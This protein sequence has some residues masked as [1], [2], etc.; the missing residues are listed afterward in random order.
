MS[1]AI[2]TGAS[3]GLGSEYAR[4]L[5]TKQKRITE[6]WLIARRLERLEKLAGELEKLRP[7]LK[8]RAIPLDLLSEADIEAYGHLLSAMKPKVSYL[9]CAAGFGRIGENADIDRKELDRMILLNDKA[10]VD[11]TQ[12]TVPYVEEKG[13]ILEICSIA[14][15][16]PL[17]GLSVYGASKAFLISYSRSLR[18]EL[19]KRKIMVTAVCPYWVKDTEFIPTAQ[20]ETKNAG[21]VKHFPLASKMK[22]V[23][24]WSLFDAGLGLAV[25]TPRPV[26][27][28]G[29]FFAKFLPHG[30]L[31]SAWEGL[32]RL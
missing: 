32:R 11:I 27:L 10:A 25:S 28:G 2:I 3:S 1:V 4:Q 9:V 22:S 30:L 17:P 7:G 23:V 15:F 26:S 20:N 16:F 8:T 24:A 21:A 29:E 31:I 19:F 13:H 12:L 18:F 6:V 14:G 5:V